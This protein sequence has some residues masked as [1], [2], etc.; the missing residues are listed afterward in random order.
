M[1]QGRNLPAVGTL[2]ARVAVVAVAAAEVLHV[3]HGQREPAAPR[4][5]GEELG[6]AD[7]AGVGRTHEVPLELLLTRYLR[8]SHATLLPV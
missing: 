6:V 4:R 7:A 8:K 3:G 2:A 1:R 5:P